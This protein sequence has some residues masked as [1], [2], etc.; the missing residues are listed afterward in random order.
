MSK[1]IHLA[2]WL[3]SRGHADTY[4]EA[5]AMQAIPYAPDEFT[6][7]GAVEDVHHIYARGMGGS[8]VIPLPEHLIGL[9]SAG[10]GVVEETHVQLREALVVAAE[11]A[12]T[13]PGHI[14]K[15]GT[16]YIYIDAP[17]GHKDLR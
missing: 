14:E 9:S 7:K 2:V 4:T 1:P 3:I 10:H 5:M 8:K 13:R 15:Q 16:R 11:A 6:R 12:I 17:Q